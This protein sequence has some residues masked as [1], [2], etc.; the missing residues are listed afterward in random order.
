[1]FLYTVFFL[2]TALINL[3]KF[4]LSNETHLVK[5]HDI[6]HLANKVRYTWV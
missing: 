6:F 2:L 4:V 1:M 3:L 5:K